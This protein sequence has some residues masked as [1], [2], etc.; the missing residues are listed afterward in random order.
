[1]NAPSTSS[2]SVELLSRVTD[3]KY[4]CFTFLFFLFLEEM[5]FLFSKISSLLQALR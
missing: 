4:G 5:L 2:F 3:V 1:M